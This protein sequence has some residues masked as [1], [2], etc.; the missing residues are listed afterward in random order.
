MQITVDSK[1]YEAAVLR[2]I[3]LNR[4]NMIAMMSINALG[5]SVIAIFFGS[6]LT[7][8]A[9]IF[10]NKLVESINGGFTVSFELGNTSISVA[11]A[12]FIPVFSALR[13]LIGLLQQNIA[14]ALDKDHSKTTSVK[15]SIENTEKRF[16]I[17]R[18]TLALTSTIIGIIIYIFL[19]MSLF[20]MDITLFVLIF[21]GLLVSMLVGLM[22]ILVNFSYLF[23]SVL[24]IPL[25]LERRFIRTMVRMNLISH[26]IKNRRTVTI[27]ALSLSFINFIY[28]TLIMQLETSQVFT[29]KQEGGDIALNARFDANGHSLFTI[30]KLLTALELSTVEDKMDYAIKFERLDTVLN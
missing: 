21:F 17:E 10:L 25:Y 9:F 28:V 27:Y 6:I 18:F 3:G 12:I 8:I 4:G 22:M 11:L 1:V 13:P 16:P 29:L 14:F 5:Y 2:T 7:A 23:E 26:R 15:V 30:G 19:P 24:L 20:A